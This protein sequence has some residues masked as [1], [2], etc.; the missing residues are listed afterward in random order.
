V[1]YEFERRVRLL[2]FT[3]PG[4]LPDVGADLY[5]QI[6]DI[7]PDWHADADDKGKIK[8]VYTG[9]PSDPADIRK[10]VRR[11]SRNKVIQ[12]RAKNPDDELEL[13]IVQSMW[14]TGFDSPPLHTLY[15][16]R[17]MRGAALMQALARVN[18]TFRDKQD[19]L[20]VGY[21]P[22]TE[23]L[24]AALAEYTAN[25]QTT[26][27]LGRDIEDA[28]AKV[29]DL[30]DTIGNVIL[31]GYD[32]RAKR[33]ERSPKAF[34]NAVL[35]TV[36]YLRDPAQ[37]GNQVDEG[38]PTLGERFRKESARLARFYALCSSSGALHGYRDDI[39][40]F[41]AARIWMAKYDAEE[42]RARGLPIPADVELYLRQ[43][44]AGAVEAGG[45]TDIYEAAGIPRPDLSHLDEAF[46]ARMQAAQNP[47][48]AIEA[49]RRLVEQQMRK[50]TR[51]NV[52][53]QQSFSD[54]LLSLMTRY[55]NQHLTAAQ[56]I[57][58]L[59]AMA[60]EVSVDAERGR[61]FS[62]PLS[63]DELAF[64]DAVAQNESA[65]TEMGTGVL[66]DIARD[67][68]KSL[69]RDVTTDWV[70]RDDV[71]A[72]L[73]STIKRLLAKHGYPPDAEPIAT[74]LVLRQME[75]FAEEWSPAIGH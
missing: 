26:K 44:T 40:F 15:V 19:G 51:H 4:N 11:P 56:V 49:L 36:D 57:A 71:R 65:V 41:E 10:H 2:M 55:T 37:P 63:G 52:V 30:H 32:W 66:A 42:R 75:T 58:E 72:K 47:H 68:V 69:R 27:P 46:I 31:S 17:P 70:S 33:A 24:Y 62:P 45:V 60:R 18:R 16:D 12:H 22:L 64:Y 29:R 54:R 59:V 21:A 25:D 1:L 13:V 50:V 6:I 39:A 53:R 8:V 67:L 61:Q 74:E 7:K 73:R 20:L 9:G 35:G 34:I 5:G 38:E 3:D 28:L 23:N 48:L 43:L 14:L